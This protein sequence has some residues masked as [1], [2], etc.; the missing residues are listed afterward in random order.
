[1]KKRGS[2]DGPWGRRVS[3][4]RLELSRFGSPRTVACKYENKQK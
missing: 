4:A 1:M 3:K 2:E